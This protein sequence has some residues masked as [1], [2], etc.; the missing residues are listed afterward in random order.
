MLQL[1]GIAAA[2]GIVIGPA[3]KLRREEW[4]IPKQRIEQADIPIQIQLF[5][6]ALIKTRREILDLQK[7]ISEDMGK[8]SAQIFEAHLLVL[9]D[10]MLTKERG[11]IGIYQLFW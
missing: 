8:D 1:R 2:P 10:R 7:R 5:E 6:E 3:Y 11:R 4:I 9:E